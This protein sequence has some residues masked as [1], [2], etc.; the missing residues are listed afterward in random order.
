VKRTRKR[1][2]A[3]DQENGKPLCR[4]GLRAMWRDRWILLGAGGRARY[5]QCHGAPPPRLC[6]LVR[7]SRPMHGVR[8]FLTGALASPLGP[9]ARRL[10][11]A[12]ERRHSHS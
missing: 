12:C 2:R 5:L 11:K 4:E 1:I 7:P 9:L 8:S 10:R 6:P 3:T